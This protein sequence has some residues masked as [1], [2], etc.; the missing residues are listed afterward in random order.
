MT[1]TTYQTVVKNQIENILTELTAFKDDA[2]P[3]THATEEVAIRAARK[4]VIIKLQELA[5]RKLIELG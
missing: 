1:K 3:R 5:H 4:A 2:P